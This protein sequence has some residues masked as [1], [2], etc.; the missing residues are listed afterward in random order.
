L[1][2]AKEIHGDKFDYSEVS[3]KNAKTYVKI[4]CREHG[5]FLQSPDKHLNSL[6]PCPCCNSIDIKTRRM[7]NRKRICKPKK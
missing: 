4:I 1:R 5:P 2:R 7:K 6:Y 3:Y